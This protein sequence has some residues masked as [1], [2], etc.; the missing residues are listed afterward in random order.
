MAKGV[1]E[2]FPLK[3]CLA[4]VPHMFTLF[5]FSVSKVLVGLLYGRIRSV[6][7]QGHLVIFI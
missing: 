2:D 4:I 5:F 3:G 6:H 1:Y 7:Q